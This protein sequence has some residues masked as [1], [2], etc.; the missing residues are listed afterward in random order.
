MF[1][2]EAK[3]LVYWMT[4]SFRDVLLQE[5]TQDWCWHGVF[6]ASTAL[7]RGKSWSALLVKLRR[8]PVVCAVKTQLCTASL[9]ILHNSQHVCQRREPELGKGHLKGTRKEGGGGWT[10][11]PHIYDHCNIPTA[12]TVTSLPPIYWTTDTTNQDHANPD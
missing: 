5:Q 8:M 3:G 1:R 7:C 4:K 6:T 2:S 12:S 9:Q 10:K 11:E